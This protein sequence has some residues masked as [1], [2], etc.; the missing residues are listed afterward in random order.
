MTYQGKFTN[1]NKYPVWDGTKF[2]SSSNYSF[3]PVASDFGPPEIV[4]G[5][6]ITASISDIPPNT[7]FSGFVDGALQLSVSLETPASS[8]VILFPLNFPQS[9]FGTEGLGERFQ[10]LWT[11]SVGAP[12]SD[13]TSFKVGPVWLDTDNS[14]SLWLNSVIT[15]SGDV[16]VNVASTLT[17]VSEFAYSS[18]P[19]AYRG[20]YWGVIDFKSNQPFDA[21]QTQFEMRTEYTSPQGNDWF[22]SNWLSTL[23]NTGSFPGPDFNGLRFDNFGLLVSLAANS[24]ATI[25]P[26]FQVV[27]RSHPDEYF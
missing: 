26:I 3:R 25:N 8:S 16:I 22:I 6:V 20:G 24:Q 12:P 17:G 10:L 23:P 5:S 13:G 4:A 27:I 11:L 21:T 2:I 9:I 18:Q 15:S 19:G 14:G 7:F 1:A